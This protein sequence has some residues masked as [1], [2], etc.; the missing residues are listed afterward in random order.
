MDEHL[1]R[2]YVFEEDFLD[3]FGDVAGA[4]AKFLDGEWWP[5]HDCDDTVRKNREYFL[6][7]GELNQLVFDG[8][9]VYHDQEGF[10]S[11]EI[12]LR[13]SKRIVNVRV[14]K[15]GQDLLAEKLVDRHASR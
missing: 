3:E 14:R 8:A 6:S 10:S 11:V 15:V 12:L 2:H 1:K 9:S 13:S 7:T 5:N 4:A